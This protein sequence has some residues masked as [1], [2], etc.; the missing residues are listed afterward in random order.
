VWCAEARDGPLAQRHH[1][2]QPCRALRRLLGGLLLLLRLRMRLGLLVCI[3]LP[4]LPGQQHSALHRGGRGRGCGLQDV[5][6]RP[7]GQAARKL[8]HSQLGVV[9]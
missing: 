5:L 7:A 8:Q 3:Q 4:P 2:Q 6:R 9:W 1:P